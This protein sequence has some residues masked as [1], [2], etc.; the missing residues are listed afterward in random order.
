MSKADDIFIQNCEDILEKGF[1]DTC[2][3]NGKMGH[4]LILSNCS[5]WSTDMTF[6]KS[7]P[8]RR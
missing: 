3:R 7:S 6:A 8:F 2:V 1:W 5:A 4:Q